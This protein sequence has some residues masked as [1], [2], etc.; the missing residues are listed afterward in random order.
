MQ[1][2][3]PLPATAQPAALAGQ[4]PLA[5]MAGLGHLNLAPQAM[6]P[7]LPPIVVTAVVMPNGAAVH[8]IQQLGQ[9]KRLRSHA[10]P[11][12]AEEA[13]HAAKLE[14][15][16]LHVAPSTKTGYKGTPGPPR[17]PRTA[18]APAPRAT[19][20]SPGRSSHPHPPRVRFRFSRSRSFLMIT[21][22]VVDVLCPVRSNTPPRV[23]GVSRGGK[24]SKKP[25]Q[26]PHSPPAP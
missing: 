17:C 25:F 22:T 5:G 10:T 11:L 4:I 3:A 1:A 26:A 8:P 6:I 13:L 9:Q 23:A 21:R 15:L 24:S 20:C 7:G 12:T 14:G 19:R 16:T 2:F 18:P